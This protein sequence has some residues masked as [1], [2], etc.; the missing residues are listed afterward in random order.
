[1]K[2]DALFAALLLPIAAV[3]GDAGLRLVA[4]AEGA[5][6]PLLNEIQRAYV[7]MPRAERVA[8]YTNETFRRTLQKEG[9]SK[10]EKVRFEWKGAKPEGASPAFEV[11]V[12]RLPDGKVFFRGGTDHHRI[13]VG[14]LEIAREYAWTVRA[15]DEIAEGTFRTEDLA[16]RL[17]DGGDVPNV[18]DLGGRVGLDGRRVR[19]GIVFRS[20]GLNYNAYDVFYTRE[21]LLA[22][23]DDPAALLAREA[24]LSNEVM[25]VRAAQWRS[26]K[27]GLVSAEIPRKWALFKPEEEAFGK[28]G[29][30][31]LAELREIP[32]EFCGAPRDKVS[33]HDAGDWYVHGRATAKGPAVLLAEIEA[34][35]LGWLSLG[36][37][38]DW[39]WTLYVNGELAFDRSG[40]NEKTPINAGNWTFP[41]RVHE[42]KNLLAVVLRPGSGGWRWYCEP[43][44]AVPVATLLDALA[45]NAQYRLDQIFHVR[46]C[47]KTG[48]SR[49]NDKNRD[50]W[51]GTLGIKTDIDLRSSGEVYG[52]EGSPLG[53]TVAWTNVSSSAY[54]G[55]QED[56]GRKQF[57]K[58]FAVFLDPANY[59]ID[60]HCIA[61]QDR[62][63]AVA[64]VLN[65]LLG[66]DE[67]QLWL[68]WELSA[69]HNRN[70]GF[71]HEKFLK[72]LHGFDRWPGETIHQRVE[73]Y[74][75]DLG[76]TPEDIAKF[77]EIMLEPAP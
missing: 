75:L 31:A 11:E 19:Q 48:E 50:Y 35:W 5:V 43:S 29:A 23:S 20:S 47:R 41:V 53:P 28:D 70:V 52:M 22:A 72:L 37:G 13:G 45:D 27:F 59:P 36:C 26:A 69:L 62:T 55:I 56:W 57:A 21:E 71:N 10:P 12:R 7:T 3:A 39:Y 9:G 63:G 16:P 60:F 30:K 73:A 8:A 74:V 40:G 34:S 68:D 1:M 38:A 65:A 51:L 4:P 33:R 67:D 54:A 64:F 44:P 17:I 2:R 32:D 66:V 25:R 76:F 46:K 42:G 49:I 58:V 14:G 6:V 77:R 18:R 15:G 61:G 24:A